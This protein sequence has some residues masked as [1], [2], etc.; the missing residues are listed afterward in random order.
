MAKRKKRGKRIVR[1]LLCLA[2]V[3]AALWIAWDQVK[4]LVV[5]ETI[6]VYEQ[7]SVE[8]GEIETSM[9][10]SGQ[11]E[12]RESE[13]FTASDRT[14]VQEVYVEA[15]QL[16]SAGDELI[17]LAN[18]ESIQA[19]IDGTV[20]ELNVSRGDAVWPQMTLATVGNLDSLRVTTSVDEYDVEDIQVGQACSV[21]VV[22]LG[23]TFETQIEH[24]NRVSSSSGSVARYTVI[25]DVDA[26]QSVLPG[27]QATVTIPTQSVA[28]VNVLP[29][30]ALSFDEDGEPYVLMQDADGAYQ[31]VTVATGLTDGMYVEITD[32]VEAGDVVFIQTGTQTQESAL[33]LEAAY[34]ALF[35]ETTVIN[36]RSASQ[37]PN[38]AEAA[39]SGEMPEGMQLPD[40]AEAPSSGEMPEGTLA[41]GETEAASSGEM[42]EGMQLPDGAGFGAQGEASAPDA[43]QTPAAEPD[44]PQQT[45]NADGGMSDAQ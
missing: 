11:I 23:L 15:D 45:Q 1:R 24:I 16:V 39:S 25:A 3:A 44:T 29:V 6:P 13:T 41:P 5:A 20:T 36:D 7:Y 10:L 38:G 19:T 2:I 4:P 8:T 14:P 26:P 34:K 43:S 21:T 17:R 22:S 18:G 12:L 31:R 33:S 28:G 32:G 40:G 27:M 42:P 30:A 9:S 35:G 37:M